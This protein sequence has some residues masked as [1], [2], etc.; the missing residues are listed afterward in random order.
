MRIGARMGAAP[1]GAGVLGALGVAAVLAFTGVLSARQEAP[2]PH[3]DHQGLFPVCTGCHQSMDAPS[4]D[5]YYPDASQCSGCHDGVDLERVSWV[6]PQERVSNVR[7]A[8]G[9]HAEELAAAGEEAATCESCH[10]AADGGRM[11]VDGTERLDTCWSCHARDEHYGATAEDRGGA[12]PS[13]EAAAACEVCHVPLAESRYDID[14]L[15]ALPAPED[16]S[17]ADFLEAGHADAAADETARCATCHTA[18]RCAACH[19]D[20]DRDA[21][22]AIPMA[23][24][25][26]EQPLW[27]ASYPTPATHEQDAWKLRHAPTQGAAECSTCHTRNDCLSCH[28]EPGP[29]VVSQHPPRSASSAPGVQIEVEPPE[30]HDSFFFMAAHANQAAAEPGTCATCHTET[31]CVSCH[32]GPADGGYHP[33]SFVAQHS[34]DAWGR[35]AECATC[36]NAAAFCREC[37]QESG[38]GSSGRLG[39]G[40]HDA[41]PVWLLRHGGAARQNLESCASCH[42]QTDCVQCHGVL[43]S[44]GVSP[45]TADFD[46]EAAWAKS[47]R[48][49]IACHTSNPLGGG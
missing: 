19:V 48:T 46:A 25:D 44:F 5:D 43:G 22:T 41:E 14:R 21:I 27:P 32:D 36:H 4:R 42:Q 26:M 7:F 20:A 37:H 30:S 2:F 23:P 40:Y 12:S 13:G 34:A 33:Q 11:S 6:G 16:H 38:L 28:V 49:C 1:R 9:G 47:P 10:S 3:P 17:T 31:Y 39:P 15:T 18:D 8:H 45:H 35:D 29:E 24:A